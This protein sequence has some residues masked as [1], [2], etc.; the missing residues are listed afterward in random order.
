M[1]STDYPGV[2]T[3]PGSFVRTK[4]V[5]LYVF[6]YIRTKPTGKSHKQ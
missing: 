5:P 4:Q 1:R 6:T 2:C 3:N